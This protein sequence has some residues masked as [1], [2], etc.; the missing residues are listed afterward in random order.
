MQPRGNSEMVNVEQGLRWASAEKTMSS[1]SLK[2][3][4]KLCPGFHVT[5]DHPLGLTLLPGT[6]QQED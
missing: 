6:E 5:L 4:A 1:K 3:G 2:G